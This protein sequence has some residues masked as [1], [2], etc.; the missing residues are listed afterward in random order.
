MLHISLNILLKTNQWKVLFIL[1]VGCVCGCLRGWETVKA[2]KQQQWRIPAVAC[3]LSFD[4][5]GL[6]LEWGLTLGHPVF[7]WVRVC[8]ERERVQVFKLC[9]CVNGSTN[10]L[11]VTLC[12]YV[13]Q[14]LKHGG[15]AVESRR[16]TGK[17]SKWSAVLE[18]D[19]EDKNRNGY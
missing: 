11:C 12:L 14:C 19:K 10:P 5:W 3:A 2:T 4:L 18:E 16:R 7:V 6:E 15:W 9:T 17:C 13:Y 1:W 8:E